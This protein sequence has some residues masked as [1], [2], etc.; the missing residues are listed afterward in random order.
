M[1]PEHFGKRDA[2][3]QDE[4]RRCWSGTGGEAGLGIGRAVWLR[5]SLKIFL[6]ASSLGNVA[7]GSMGLSLPWE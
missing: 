4:R 6:V 1:P 5:G 3:M 7:V 2:L